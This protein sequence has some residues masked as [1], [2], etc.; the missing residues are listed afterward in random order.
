MPV[1][2]GTR[3]VFLPFFYDEQTVRTRAKNKKFIV[4]EGQG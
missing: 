2:R 3:Y 1:T 4:W